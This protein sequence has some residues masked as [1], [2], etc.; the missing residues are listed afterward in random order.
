[1]PRLPPNTN[2][3]PVVAVLRTIVLGTAVLRTGGPRTA[4]I[5]LSTGV[6]GALPDVLA[7]HLLDSRPWRGH[8][9]CV[10]R[11][12]HRRRR[13]AI[14]GVAARSARARAPAARV[15]R[16]RLRRRRSSRRDRR[17]RA[18]GGPRAAIGPPAN[19][20]WAGGAV[21]PGGA[22]DHCPA[23]RLAPRARNDRDRGRRVHRAQRPAAARPHRRSWT[24]ALGWHRERPAPRRHAAPAA[25]SRGHVQLAHRSRSS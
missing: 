10:E 12:Q 13:A 3:S 5:G 4:R 25:S 24:S 17:C 9:R 16:Q 1:M 19:P 2:G 21:D 18:A 7:G 22:V 8:R 6:P 20:A 14:V 11:L 23:P 15:I